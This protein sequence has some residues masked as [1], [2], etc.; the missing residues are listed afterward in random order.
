MSAATT[1]YTDGVA[2]CEPRPDA[3]SY[4]VAMQDRTGTARSFTLDLTACGAMRAAIGTPAV[5]TYLGL[6][7]EELVRAVG[8]SEP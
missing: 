1:G 7:S 3:T 6:A 2:D 4:L 5:D 8:Q